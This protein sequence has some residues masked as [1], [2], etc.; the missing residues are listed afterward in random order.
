MHGYDNADYDEA[1]KTDEPIAAGAPVGPDHVALLGTLGTYVV[2][3]AGATDNAIARFDGATGYVIQNSGLLLDDFG[4]LSKSGDLD[5]DCGAGNTI[6]LTQT[7]WDDIQFP[8]ST[9]KIPAANFPSY[10]AFTTNTQQYKFDVDDYIN[11]EAE[12]L[13]HWWKEGTGIYPHVH[14]ALDG[15]NASGGSYYVKFTIYLAYADENAVYTEINRDIEI[16]IPDGTAD[17]THIFGQAAVV[18]MAG[19]TI[20]TQMV[21]RVKRIAATSGTEYPNDIFITQVGVHAEKDTLGSRLIG[22]K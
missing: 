6:K 2:G 20:G 17:M 19:I 9:G 5:I 1:I 22:T 7:V 14:A 11:L 8:I 13:A 21:A 15:A 10:A 3:P 12:E 4:N 16:E 18:S